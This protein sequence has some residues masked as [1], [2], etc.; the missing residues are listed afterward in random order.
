MMLSTFISFS[1]LFFMLSTVNKCEGMPPASV[2]ANESYS[3][4]RRI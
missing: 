4:K 3:G 1:L 2:V